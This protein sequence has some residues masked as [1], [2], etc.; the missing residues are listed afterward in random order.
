MTRKGKK[1]EWTKQCEQSFQ[2]LKEKL[3]SAL[4]LIIPEGIDGFVIYSDASKIGFRVV[5]MQHYKVVA[6]ASRKIND[7]ER[8]YLTHD[9][10]LAVV[11]F[12]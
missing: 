1:F 7:Y 10:E 5:L 12:V 6:Y 2:E 3:T 8:N 9:L 4:V 11:V